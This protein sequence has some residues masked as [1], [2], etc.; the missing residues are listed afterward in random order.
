MQ[1]IVEFYDLMTP[2]VP[3][4]NFCVDENIKIGDG[5]HPVCPS[6][7]SKSTIVAGIRRNKNGVIETFLTKD[8]IT[9][10]KDYKKIVLILIILLLLYTIS[11]CSSV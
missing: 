11:S 3:I 8:A 1:S 6:N 5:R 4:H 2:L 10:E 9:K 7:L